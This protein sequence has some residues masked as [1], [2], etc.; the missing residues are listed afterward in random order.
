MKK[1][2]SITKVLEQTRSLE[3]EKILTD[4]MGWISRLEPEHNQVIVDYEL[5]PLHR[6]VSAQISNPKLTLEDLKNAESASWKVLLG[7]I[8]GNPEQP[9]IKDVLCSVADL[10][11]KNTALKNKTLHLKGDEIILEADSKVTIKCG[12]SKTTY[13][14]E[15]NRIVEEADRIHSFA[16]FTHKLKGGSVAIN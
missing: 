12:R 4:R 10:N 11:D 7:F 1:T 2:V 8:N 3:A 13:L 6:P 14:A 16:R 9:V 5:N 15:G